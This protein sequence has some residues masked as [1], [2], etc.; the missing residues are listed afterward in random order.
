MDKKLVF[1]WPSGGG[2]WIESAAKSRH[3]DK[4]FKALLH[5]KSGNPNAPKELQEG[6]IYSVTR[7]EARALITALQET[8][9][10]APASPAH[11]DVAS[12]DY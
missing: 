1:E 2:I 3:E 11:S 8:I 4:G 6:W 7:D 10:D 12:F 5:I 9:S